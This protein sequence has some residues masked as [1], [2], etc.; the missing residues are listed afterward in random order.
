V[1]ERVLVALRRHPSA[2]EVIEAA[3]EAYR[4]ERQQLSREASKARGSI[5]RDLAATEREIELVMRAVK[6]GAPTSVTVPQLQ[7]LAARQEQLQKQL[8][9]ASN[10]DVVELHPNAAQQYAGQV[11]AI[12]EALSAGDGADLDAVMLVRKLITQVRVTPTPK[13]EPVGLEVAGDL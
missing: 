11:A 4:E 10:P 7:A 8:A 3:V 2:P 13:G 5:Q 1:Q 6:D 12:H 9:A